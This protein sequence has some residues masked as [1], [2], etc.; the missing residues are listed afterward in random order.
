MKFLPKVVVGF[1]ISSLAVAAAASAPLD[2]SHEVEKHL[3]DLTLAA[4]HGHARTRLGAPN[5]FSVSRKL[6]DDEDD[7]SSDDNDG[8]R[9]K[10][11]ALLTEVM[12]HQ[13]DNIDSIMSQYEG[14]EESLLQSLQ[15]MK[16]NKDAANGVTSQSGSSGQAEGSGGQS[17][18]SGGQAGGS[19]GQPSGSGGQSAG[20]SVQSADGSGTTALPDARPFTEQ[21]PFQDC[22]AAQMGIIPTEMDALAQCYPSMGTPLA[23]LETMVQQMTATLG[24]N[25]MVDEIVQTAFQPILDLMKE[26]APLLGEEINAEALALI[27]KGQNDV[28]DL[29]S[30]LA[31]Q[32]ASAVTG[33]VEDISDATI[34]Q[35][36]GG[37]ESGLGFDGQ[38]CVGDFPGRKI[39]SPDKDDVMT[40]IC[41]GLP[42]KAKNGEEWTVFASD[43]N[44]PADIDAQVCGGEGKDRKMSSCLAV[45]MCDVLPSVAF[46]FDHETTMCLSARLEQVVNGIANLLH[47][48]EG[49]DTAV[50]F[51]LSNAFNVHTEV[52]GGKDHFSYKASPELYTQMSSKLESKIIS[53]DLDGWF[54]ITG[55]LR[56]GFNILN[57]LG[58]PVPEDLIANALAHIDQ[59]NPE[60]IIKTF[61]S[62]VV[63]YTLQGRFKLKVGFDKMPYIG[64]LL[65]PFDVQFDDASIVVSSGKS[66]L[67][68]DNGEK[69]EIYPGF[70][71]YMGLGGN[72]KA[73]RTTVTQILLTMDGLMDLMLAEMP[74]GPLFQS[75]A[76]FASEIGTE[77]I[78]KRLEFVQED[79]SKD[80]GFGVRADIEGAGFKLKLPLRL[81]ENDLTEFNLDCSTDFESFKCDPSIGN[82]QGFFAAL[83]KDMADGSLLILKKFS[84][85]FVKGA[86]EAGETISM[87]M[88]KAGAKAGEVF[89]KENIEQ[90][91]KDVMEG[92]MDGLEEDL[93]EI[94]SIGYAA[95]SAFCKSEGSCMPDGE[96]CVGDPFG[97]KKKQGS[98]CGCCNDETLWL[99]KTSL[100]LP[101]QACGQEP[102][103]K[104]GTVCIPG[105]SC[106]M[107]QNGDNQWDSVPDL[108]GL[109]G[110]ACGPEP[111]IPDGSA[112][113]GLSC[114]RCCSGTNMFAKCGKQGCLGDGT[115]CLIGTT[116][117]DCC[118]GDSWWWSKGLGSQACGTEP[119]W[120]DGQPC[121]KGI[122][123]HMCSSGHS[124]YWMNPPGS[125]LPAEAC[126]KEPCWPDGKN[127]VNGI[128][129]HQCCSKNNM[130]FKCGKQGCWGDGT[131]C[132]FGGCK[133]CCSHE[134][135][136]W[137]DKVSNACG[138]Q[139]CWGGGREC[140][141]AC[142]RC[143]GGS[144]E[145]KQ[146]FWDLFPKRYCN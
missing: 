109:P 88:D 50:G 61:D 21:V 110:R 114:K 15:T 90:T 59:F 117:F 56:Q 92:N 130:E 113:F 121:V 102:K 108:L 1:L 33:A 73:I 81:S 54:T 64:H 2:R 10:I 80:Y 6:D 68:L 14:K 71:T 58:L 65:K 53:P 144:H 11:L 76:D 101:G 51:T 89:K 13:V 95:L 49:I 60:K 52:Y 97:N 74:L 137:D 17:S 86:E 129:C 38:I 48:G 34:G 123:C 45:S 120:G 39:V 46:I 87:A 118:N 27:Q 75:S 136:W 103:W 77:F 107:C 142:G 139:P 138:K 132:I 83:A 91:L 111:C 140:G 47:S 119:K 125:F 124:T 30:D 116:C 62:V 104:D 26:L 32:A 100:N 79:P 24:Q 29:T 57:P 18:G 127:C 22:A 55:N 96:A 69:A 36:L 122:S 82:I 43:L 19:G 70:S 9:A 7:S 133:N 143:C 63:T 141:L 135:S 40:G 23:L 112:C 78:L 31:D 128:S 37:I 3:D 126:G 41:S 4:G 25:L 93:K 20:T 99:G 131:P 67:T 72:A 94:A 44:L 146:G 85:D 145:R 5:N 66:T 8:M 106:H 84:E 105:I 42:L 98:C 134:N 35:A 12:P 16:A 28:N 115:V